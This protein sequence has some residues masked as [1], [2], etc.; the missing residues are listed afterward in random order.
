MRILKQLLLIFFVGLGI[1]KVVHDIWLWIDPAFAVSISDGYFSV[2][3]FA[4]LYFSVK[5][6]KQRDAAPAGETN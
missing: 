6:L 1:Q 3:A 2:L 5:Y 4:L